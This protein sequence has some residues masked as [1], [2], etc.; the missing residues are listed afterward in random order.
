MRKTLRVISVTAGIISLV[1][2]IVLGYLYIE[3]IAEYLKN[4]KGRLERR[5]E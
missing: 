5:K 3:D 1:A 2:V 4:T